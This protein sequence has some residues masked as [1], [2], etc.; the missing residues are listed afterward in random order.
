[1]AAMRVVALAAI[2]IL[3]LL[4]TAYVSASLLILQPPRANVPAWFAL[5]AV[6]TFQCA[7]TLIALG[8][9]R[10]PGWIR[11]LVLGGACAL[12]AIAVWR[13]RDTLTSS[14]FEGYNLLLALILVVQAALTIAA[15]VRSRAFR[16]A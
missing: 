9:T 3:T 4:A 15:F 10:P 1:M 16:T 2:C 5:A 8:M 6:F 11:F 14:H 13:V 7:L 12:V